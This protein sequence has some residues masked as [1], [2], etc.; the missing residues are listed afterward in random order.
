MQF[1][2]TSMWKKCKHTQQTV[3]TWNTKRKKHKLWNSVQQDWRRWSRWHNFV[4]IY[5][6][7]CLWMWWWPTSSANKV[8]T[9]T[10]FEVR[11]LGYHI[12]RH[13]E[14]FIDG[15][16]S[17]NCFHGDY[18]RILHKR[19]TC[20]KLPQEKTSHQRKCR[21]RPS[22][23]AYFEALNIHALLRV[24]CTRKTLRQRLVLRVNM[25]LPGTGKVSPLVKLEMIGAVETLGA[26]ST[27]V[28]PDPE[29]Y[30][31]VP[32]AG[33]RHA[34]FT[35]A[36]L[37]LSSGFIFCTLGWIS[38]HLERSWREKKRWRHKTVGRRFGFAKWRWTKITNEMRGKNNSW[39]TRW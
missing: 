33:G 38:R 25:R 28:G 12:H 3:W 34:E 1:G 24:T 8:W 19:K 31:F 21:D 15:G 11:Q 39:E 13:Q 37:A 5:K 6:G 10:T 35:V 27:L 2:K 16:G 4:A 17:A 22:R 30:E 36:E 9:G 29:M 23:I 26:I 7:R 14:Q 32:L 18:L 20:K